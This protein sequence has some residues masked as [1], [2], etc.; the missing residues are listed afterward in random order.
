MLLQSP[1]L[2]LKAVCTLFKTLQKFMEKLCEDF[3]DV[4]SCARS[5]MDDVAQMYQSENWRTRI[6]KVSH[7]ELTSSNVTLN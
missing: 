7:D 3:E 1:D 5:K 4:E 2:D 6:R